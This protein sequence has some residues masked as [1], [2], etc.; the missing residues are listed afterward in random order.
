MSERERSEAAERPSTVERYGLQPTL[1]REV[2]TALAEGAGPVALE[3][4]LEPLHAADLADL[5]AQLPREL[6][7]RLVETMGR[8]LDPEAFIELDGAVLADA[9]E[10]MA[11][12][13]IAAAVERL[14]TDDAVYL[15]ENVPEDRRAAVLS[16]I[17]APDRAAVLE[18]LT[19]PEE[20][21]GRLMQRDLVAVPAYWT[22]GQVIDYLREAPDLPDEF[23]EIYIVDPRHRPIGHVPLYRAMRAKRPAMMRDLVDEETRVIPLDMDQEEV[24]RLFQQYRMTSAPVVDG[25]GRLV[26][27]ITFDDAVEVLSE[28]TEEDMLRLAGVGEDADLHDPVLRT[29]RKRFTWLLVNLATAFLAA[30]VISLF[31]ATIEA[32]VAVAI[33]MPIVASL[34]GNAGLQAMTVTVR[35]LATRELTAANALRVVGKETM[36]GFLNGAAFALLVGAIAAV[37]FDAPLIGAVIA[38]AMVTNML[39]AGLAGTLIP[40]TLQRLGA[41]PAVAATVFLTTVTDVF[42][43]FAFL[44]LATLVLL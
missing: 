6:R 23:Y 7:H 4:I 35:A 3:I 11:P 44:G 28:E 27:V 20:S 12:S 13:D 39:I 16:E 41:D 5:I 2:E 40:L 18:G 37:W 42:G 36:V 34:G 32:I 22:V 14:D 19:Y 15:L 30:F 21:A 43:F 31:D 29:T 25:A 33:L 10:R 26:G 38:A 1:V 24:A 9:L 17:P 8:R